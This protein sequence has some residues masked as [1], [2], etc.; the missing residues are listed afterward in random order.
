MTGYR[1][2]GSGCRAIRRRVL[3]WVDVAT[4]SLGQ[5]LPDGVG[6]A[7]AGKY[8][9][10]CRYRVWVLCGDSEMAEG[11]MWEALD[12]AAYYGL[13]NLIAIVDVN[14][15]GQRGPTE[16]GWDTRRLRPPARGV[17]RARHRDRRPRSRR[18]RRG[19]SPRRRA[20]AA[21]PTV[22]LARPSRAR[23]SPRSRTARAGT[24]SRCPPTWPD[25]AIAELGGDR[26]LR[27]PR[28]ACRR[29]PGRAGA[30][31]PAPQIDLPPLR[32]RRRRSPPARPTARR[33]PRSAPRAATS[34]PWTARSAT[35]PTPRS[36]RKAHP[37]RFFEMYI[38]E[39]QIVA[40]AV[41]LQ[42]AR[43]D[44]RS[45][46]PSPRSSP[47]PTTSS[48]WPPSAAPTSACAAR[49]PAS[50]SARTAPRRWR[51]RTWR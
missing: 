25:A 41:G 49:T 23:A 8:L 12:K 44:R 14:R 29:A 22:I 6:V 3:P 19:A 27:R 40:A 1:R 18:D 2:F 45:P 21:S 31:A 4:G 20:R 17:R 26:D 9:D 13:A 28:S 48:G 37:D 36:S 33:W 42:R 51:W 30:G 34:W 24:A 11:S 46:R 38:A 5:G 15:L 7:L 39:Q 35:P 43:L 50:R 16:L 10:G 32:A 47:A